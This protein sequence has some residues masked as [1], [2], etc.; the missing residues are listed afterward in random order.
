MWLQTTRVNL[1][2]DLN[3]PARYM[4]YKI[5][6]LIN[7]KIYIG[8]TINLE[9]RWYYHCWNAQH[10][11]S[12]RLYIAMRK[13]GIENFAIEKIND[14]YDKEEILAI[15]EHAPDYNMT[16]GGDGGNTSNSP[17][18]KRAMFMRDFHGKNNPNYGKRGKDNPKYGKKYGKKPNISNAKKKVLKCSNGN[19]FKGFEE[20]WKYYGVRSYFSLRK[21]GI[22]WS[23]VKYDKN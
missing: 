1:S 8:K 18:F 21:K 11:K 7:G 4:I 17:N 6:N 19:I 16:K 3:G 14:G 5:T 10:G 22:T 2:Y 12:T 20:M 13:H 9:R 23:E 15:Q